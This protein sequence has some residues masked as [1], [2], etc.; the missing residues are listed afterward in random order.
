M[1][2]P[3]LVVELVAERVRIVKRLHHVPVAVAGLVL[4]FHQI[5]EGE[6]VAPRVVE[7]AV[8]D[9]AHPALVRFG[10]H[11]QEHLVRRRPLPRRGVASDLL[12]HDREVALRVGAEVRIDVMVGVPIVLV[13]RTGVKQRIEINRVHPEVGDV[14]EFVEHALQVAAEAPVEH[15][16][17]EKIRPDLQLPRGAF[18]PVVRPRRNPPPR[19]RRDWPLERIARGI[20]GLVAVAETLRENLV[21]HHILRPVRAIE[22]DFCLRCRLG[23]LWGL[24]GLI[25]RLAAAG[26]QNCKGGKDEG[27]ELR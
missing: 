1:P 24:R 4:V 27:T 15:A 22:R 17:P 25:R 21:P 8:E 18:V 23:G 2:P 19:R 16:V 11:L 6:K 7:H 5:P 26:E 3:A 12:F 13:E 14:V 10:K 9:H 20:V